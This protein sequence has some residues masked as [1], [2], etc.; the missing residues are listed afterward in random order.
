MSARKQKEMRKGYHDAG[1]IYWTADMEKR[2]RRIYRSRTIWMV[3]A[4]LALIL[5]IGSV[6]HARGLF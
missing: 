5:D 2:I 4:L 6:L 3:V 1:A